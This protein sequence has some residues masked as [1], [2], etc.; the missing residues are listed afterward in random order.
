MIS[1]QISAVYNFFQWKNI[2]FSPKTSLNFF[3]RKNRWNSIK[4]WE[5]CEIT[6]SYSFFIEKVSET[7]PK[8]FSWRDPSDNF[9][10]FSFFS[11]SIFKFLPYFRHEKRKKA[12]KQCAC[13]TRL[14][15]RVFRFHCAQMLQVSHRRPLFV[16]FRRIKQEKINARMGLR[17][18]VNL[19]D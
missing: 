17:S 1:S 7:S 5:I 4:I 16:S 6:F 9:L 11:C 12:S 8:P 10:F 3:S 13:S 15:S 2:F 14:I 19:K 18:C